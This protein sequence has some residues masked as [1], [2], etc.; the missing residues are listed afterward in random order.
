MAEAVPPEVTREA[1]YAWAWRARRLDLLLHN[2][3]AP[4][5][6]GQL[7]ALELTRSAKARGIMRVVFEIGRR[8]GKSHFFCVWALMLALA[9]EGARVPYAASTRVSLREFIIPIM[10]GLLATAPEDMRP[11]IVGNEV[12]VML[13]GWKTPS[14]IV[15]VGCE[16]RTAADLLR[17]P[18]ADG[19]VVDEAG[20]IAPLKYLVS[21]VLSFQLATTDGL[22]LLGSS[23]PASTEH[24]FIEFAKTAEERGAY[25]RG[26]IWDTP[27][28]SP[29]MIEKLCAEEG[30][31]ESPGWRRE[32]LAER[33]VD[34]TLAIVPEFSAL[35]SS[36]VVDRAH[37]PHV[38]RY[39][40]GDLGYV[41]LSV[42]LFAVWLFD[43]ATIYVIDELSLERTTSTEVQQLVNAKEV[44]LWGEKKIHK[45]V[46]DAP[47]IT[48]ADMVRLQRPGEPSAMWQAAR[49]DDLAAAVNG[50]RTTVS[51]KKLLVHPRCTTLIAHMRGG[52]WDDR[53]KKFE[54]SAG[55]GH[56]DAI[57]A[58]MYL[59]RHVDQRHNPQPPAVYDKASQFVPASALVPQD[60]L[61]RRARSLNALLTPPRKR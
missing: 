46:L 3:T 53:R 2:G 21:D 43:E 47:A 60:E 7:R 34:P 25:M 45:R 39:V 54:R 27:F 44:E 38:D 31:A 49:T 4:R 51:R 50:L 10:T 40:V 28:I 35:Q 14:R 57:A 6:N 12:R 24:A 48:R 9:R 52:V 55:L 18:S 5:H 23:T 33:I 42:I 1:V 58:A 26:T 13:D 32:A 8:F 37:T 22:M 41:D 36:V 17:G 11:Q 30:G 29:A 19:A 15:L 16:D 59:V 20:F 56:F 61:A